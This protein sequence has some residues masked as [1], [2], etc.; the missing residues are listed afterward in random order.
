MTGEKKVTEVIINLKT[1]NAM[2]DKAPLHLTQTLKKIE[3]L[4]EE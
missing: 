1:H 3:R 2:R 4:F